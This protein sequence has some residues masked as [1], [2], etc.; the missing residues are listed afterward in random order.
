MNEFEALSRDKVKNVRIIVA[1]VI[2]KHF[3]GKGCLIKL[4]S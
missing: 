2:K 3:K 1:K 4:L